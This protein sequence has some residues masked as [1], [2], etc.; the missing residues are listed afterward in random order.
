MRLPALTIS[1]SARPCSL[2]LER[3]KLLA[4]GA[5]A[6]ALAGAM[7]LKPRL[8]RQAG[9]LLVSG[10]NIDINLLD[11]IIG[12]GLVKAG[13]LFRFRV[14]LADRPAE[15]SRLLDLIGGLGANVSA[16][17]HDRTQRDVALGAALVELELETRGCHH[18]E[19]IRAKLKQHGYRID[20]AD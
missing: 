2:L 18:I 15:L 14:N 13:R 16:I 6:A 5:G 11:R 8:E 1:K 9:C 10:G 20:D 12:H 17:D 3:M 19:L 7:K 4:E